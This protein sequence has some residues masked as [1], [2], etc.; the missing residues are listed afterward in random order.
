MG[1]Q[2]ARSRPA[3]AR[4]LSL[5]LLRLFSPSPLI[6][7][8]LASNQMIQCWSPVPLACLVAVV[9]RETPLSPGD[10]TGGG[11]GGHTRGAGHVRAVPQPVHCCHGRCARKMVPLSPR[12]IRRDSSKSMRTGP[13][14]WMEWM[15]R[16][17][18]FWQRDRD[19]FG[20]H[21]VGIWYGVYSA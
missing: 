21:R 9:T 1:N 16:H 3:V 14:R 2:R 18:L 5:L 8:F 20:S 17:T 11:E 6:I 13:S 19:P 15:I 12:G 4:L 10:Y 7:L